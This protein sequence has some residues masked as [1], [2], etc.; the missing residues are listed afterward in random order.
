[1][2]LRFL[3]PQDPSPDEI[4]HAARGH[5]AP[6]SLGAAQTTGRLAP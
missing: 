1:M 2:H 3:V 4:T 6:L 5:A